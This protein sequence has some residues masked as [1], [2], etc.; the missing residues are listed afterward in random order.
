MY[1]VTSNRRADWMQSAAIM[2]ARRTR[3]LG[4]EIFGDREARHQGFQG[5][6]M[7]ICPAI[8]VAADL[9][10][11]PIDVPELGRGGMCIEEIV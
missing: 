6:F 4:L 11:Q 2:F 7:N 1:S 5:M 10:L 3:E 8:R 9:R